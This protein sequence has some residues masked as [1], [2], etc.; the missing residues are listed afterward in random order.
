MEMFMQIKRI[1]NAE[2][3]RKVA[4]DSGGHTNRWIRE[5]LEKHHHRI[6]ST[7]QIQQVLGTTRERGFKADKYVQRKA[8]DLIE[9]CGFDHGLAVMVLAEMGEA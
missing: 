3:I 7:Q 6:V 4:N 1:S 9:A 8:A 2:L 5:V